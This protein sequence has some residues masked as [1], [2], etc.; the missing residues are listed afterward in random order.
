MKN[1]KAVL[2]FVLVLILTLTLAGLTFYKIAEIFGLHQT[3][4]AADSFHSFAHKINDTAVRPVGTKQSMPL[5][6]DEKSAIMGFSRDSNRIV[7]GNSWDKMKE[8]GLKS[9]IASAGI[10]LGPAGPVAAGWFAFTFIEEDTFVHFSHRPG[11]C[12]DGACFCL[13]RDYDWRYWEGGGKIPQSTDVACQ[14]EPI[15]YTFRN[16]DFPAKLSSDD[17]GLNYEQ[18]GGFIIAKNNALGT[19]DLDARLNAVYITK[20][21]DDIVSVSFSSKG[22]SDEALREY[23]KTLGAKKIYNKAHRAYGNKDY[24]AAIDG[25]ERLIKADLTEQISSGQKDAAYYLLGMAYHKKGEDEK[26][27]EAFDEALSHIEG[28]ELREHIREKMDEI[29]AED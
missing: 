12:G 8:Y 27:I 14:E 29:E 19:K 16:F 28:K 22:V 13:C 7:A 20:E 21:D 18:E 4:K 9:A 3:N 15:C 17:F 25:F 26:A 2:G 23:H 24:D 6:V 10:G 11:E 5:Y 1:K